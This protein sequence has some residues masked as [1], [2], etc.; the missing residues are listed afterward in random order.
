[1]PK[2]Q[3]LADLEGYADPMDMLEEASM[4]S[5]CPGICMNPNCDYTIEVEPDQTKGWC[6]DCQTNTV[7]SALVLAGVI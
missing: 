7:K 3:R 1:M 5:I 2:L 4:D 6:E